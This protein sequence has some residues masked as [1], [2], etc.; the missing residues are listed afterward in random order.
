MF[1]TCFNF[2]C[3]LFF[4]KIIAYPLILFCGGFFTYNK[5]LL[6]TSDAR[7]Q[8]AC[9]IIYLNMLLIQCGYFLLKI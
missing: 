5:Q 1:H 3:M 4:F 6:K 2:D 8:A 9:V 7:S